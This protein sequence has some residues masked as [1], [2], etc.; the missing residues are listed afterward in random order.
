MRAS[1]A[2]L[3]IFVRAALLL[4]GRESFL[5]SVGDL[6]VVAS[7]GEAFQPFGWG[8]GDMV[9]RGGRGAGNRVVGRHVRA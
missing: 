7:E 2:A 6:W 8:A 3:P 4:L 9:L 1:C 5:P